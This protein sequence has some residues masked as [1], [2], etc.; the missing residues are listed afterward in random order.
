MWHVYNQGLKAVCVRMVCGKQVQ[1]Q[2]YVTSAFDR[3]WSASRLDHF[4]LG[5]KGPWAPNRGRVGPRACVDA[6]EKRKYLTSSR[7]SKDAINKITSKTA[8]WIRKITRSPNITNRTWLPWECRI[9]SNNNWPQKLLFH[10]HERRCRTIQFRNCFVLS[11]A[12]MDSQ[13]PKQVMQVTSITENM[14]HTLQRDASIFSA[15]TCR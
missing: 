5:K 12:C 10:I 14:R 6:L 15:L 3:A 2:S 4:T 7:E 1:F 13:T 8:R 11:P 9:V